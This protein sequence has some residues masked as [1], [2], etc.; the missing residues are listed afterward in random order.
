MAAKQDSRQY[1]GCRAWDVENKSQIVSRDV[2]T[3]LIPRILVFLG[4]MW[5]SGFD[6]YRHFE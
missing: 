2:S 1:R 4:A 6:R 3:V 5:Y